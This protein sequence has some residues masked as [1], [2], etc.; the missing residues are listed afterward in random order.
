MKW[1]DRAGFHYH[2]KD[3][4]GVSKWVG[5][6]DKALR[7]LAIGFLIY[8]GIAAI[9]LL[10]MLTYA[11]LTLSWPNVLN[12]LFF[13]AFTHTLTFGGVGLW[14]LRMRRHILSLATPD[15]VSERFGVPRATLELIAQEKGIK[16]RM[17]LNGLDYYNPADF[18]SDAVT[19]LRGTT[20]PQE[21]QEVL[22]RPA[23]DTRTTAPEQLLRVPNTTSAADTN[24]FTVT[25]PASANIEQQ[26]IQSMPS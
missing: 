17:N 12:V 14:S 20:Q 11:L 15:Q 3:K 24:R 22:L 1:D 21:G 9:A 8:G 4:R 5:G 18:D 19:L 6:W 2:G 13:I 23:N 25:M 10:G 26:E 7:G 16:P